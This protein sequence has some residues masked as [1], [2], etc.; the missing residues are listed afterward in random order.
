MWV[1]MLL[2]DL[3]GLIALIVAITGTLT[4]LWGFA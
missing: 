2:A 1:R 3:A 4:I